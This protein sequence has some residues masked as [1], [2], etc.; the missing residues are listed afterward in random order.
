MVAA[1]A[2][3]ETLALS[4]GQSIGDATKIEEMENTSPGKPDRSELVF[5]AELSSSPEWFASELAFDEIKIECIIL[6]R[7]ALKDKSHN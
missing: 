1:K 2:K 4:I 7:F 3:A 5:K 6:A